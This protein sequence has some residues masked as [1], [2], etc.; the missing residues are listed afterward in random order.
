MGRLNMKPKDYIIIILL[1]VAMLFMYWDATKMSEA[2][3]A[4]NQALEIFHRTNNT[5]AMAEYFC[6]FQLKTPIN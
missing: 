6:N 3:K 4:C 1:L 5:C 2:S